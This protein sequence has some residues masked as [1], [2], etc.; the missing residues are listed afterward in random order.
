MAEFALASMTRSSD[1]RAY[2]VVMKRTTLLIVLCVL[3]LTGCGVRFAYNNLDWL[4]MRWVD[5]QV[6]LDAD[7]R[8][9]V[10][11]IIDQR[12]AWHCASELPLYADFLRELAADV[13]ADRLDRDR[14]ADHGQTLAEF[15]RRLLDAIH[16][17]LID[18]MLSLS[19]A[20]VEDLKESFAEANEEIRAEQVEVAD[21]VRQR[22]RVRGMSRSLRRFYGSLN[23]DQLSRLETWAGELSRDDA[24]MLEDRLTWQARLFEALE[25]RD[26]PE[27]FIREVAPLLEPGENWSA[28][29]RA[30]LEANRELTLDALADVH[31]LATVRQRRR[32][33]SRLEGFADDFERLRCFAEQ[34]G[35]RSEGIC[36]HAPQ[37]PCNEYRRYF[38]AGLIG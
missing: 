10:E 24:L 18:V 26:E 6:A 27:L 15:G 17:D 38:V 8:R 25:L 32:L 16:D 9:Q 3:L 2:T 33:V 11:D 29:Y 37:M 19:D 4:V 21:S 34:P 23:R 30:V 28:D 5:R 22:D 7:Q 35:P 20:Q 36:G 31:E 12:R 14:L 1:F 13:E